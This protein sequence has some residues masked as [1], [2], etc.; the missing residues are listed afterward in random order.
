LRQA[1]RGNYGEH[2]ERRDEES[3]IHEGTFSGWFG[4]SSYQSHGQ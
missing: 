3:T 4:A 1:I 2:G